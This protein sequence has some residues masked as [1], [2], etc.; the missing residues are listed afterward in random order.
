MKK[1]KQKPTVVCHTF[2]V[3]YPKVDVRLPVGAK[4]L[5][6]EASGFGIKIFA[7]ADP[8]VE[9][10]ENYVIRIAEKGEE[11][12]TNIGYSLIGEVKLSRHEVYRVYY[13]KGYLS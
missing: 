7:D 8:A 5:R 1:S 3:A 11:V 4:N 13:Y 9:E 2:G 10:T 6:A 12:S